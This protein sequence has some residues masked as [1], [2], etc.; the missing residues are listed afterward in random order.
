MAYFG[1]SGMDAMYEGPRIE[2][3]RETA[4]Q[5]LKLLD[6]HHGNISMS[7]PEHMKHCV[8]KARSK[9]DAERAKVRGDVMKRLDMLE[10]I[11]TY[12]QRHGLSVIWD[13]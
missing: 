5:T 13:I 4:R 2:L 6:L 11:A 1:A 10:K 12:A 8:S 9:S 3:D 7:T